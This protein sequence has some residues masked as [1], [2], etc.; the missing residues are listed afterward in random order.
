[1]LQGRLVLI[2]AYLSYP[3]LYTHVR[4]KHEGTFPEG[5]KSQKDQKS[6]K[7]LFKAENIPASVYLQNHMEGTAQTEPWVTTFNFTNP[8][9]LNG[10]HSVQVLVYIRG[11]FKQMLSKFVDNCS[12]HVMHGSL[13]DTDSLD[14]LYVALS[15]NIT[16]EVFSLQPM[17][18]SLDQVG[19]LLSC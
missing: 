6:K 14:H 19:R 9:S 10:E 15:Q 18:A 2:Q 7:A 16:P 4:N 1:M 17:R 5:S 13:K 3:A 12:D 11:I 8:I